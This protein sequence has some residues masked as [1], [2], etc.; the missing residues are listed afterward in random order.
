MINRRYMDLSRVLEF[1]FFFF[2]ILASL[3]LGCSIQA[4]SSCGRQ[5]ASL[6]V[7]RR[8]RGRQGFS[9]YPQACEILVP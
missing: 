8:G 1:F 5:G 6:V 2:L 7:V 9:T 4:S 3:G